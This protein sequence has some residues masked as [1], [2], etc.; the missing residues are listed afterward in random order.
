MCQTHRRY[1]QNSR[2]DFREFRVIR[3]RSTIISTWTTVSEQQARPYFLVFLLPVP[4]MW[5][6]LI[7]PFTVAGRK[8][9][10]A[11]PSSNLT[12]ALRIA[13]VAR[14]PSSKS[15]RTSDRR[16]VHV[17]VHIDE[18]R[19]AQCRCSPTTPATRIVLDDCVPKV[20]GRNIAPTPG[21]MHSEY[22]LLSYLP[23]RP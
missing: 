12:C 13:A 8:G 5:T 23:D 14:R 15:Q 2:D 18:R 16:M 19:V 10:F 9:R 4:L 22:T 1:E 21:A 11:N 20:T 3:K 17:I 7:I 6:K